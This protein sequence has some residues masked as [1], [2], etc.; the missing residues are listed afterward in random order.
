MHKERKF[1]GRDVP[2]NG[3]L[4]LPLVTALHANLG[5]AVLTPFE[6]LSFKKLKISSLFSLMHQVY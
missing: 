5:L 4:H 1:G 6:L 2:A 3:A